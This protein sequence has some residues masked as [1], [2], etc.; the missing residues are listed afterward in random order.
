MHAAVGEQARERAVDDGRPDLRLD[1]VADDRQARLA[2]AVGP[3]ALLG[4]EHR[5]A[6]HEPA[7]GLEDL[8]DVPLGGL[9]G[10]DREVGDD[11]VGLGLLEDLD[12][13]IGLARRL[14][15][16]LLE[17]LAE[18]VVRHAAVHR[19]VEVGHVGEL[20]RVVLTRPDRLAEVLADLVGVDVERGR[21][22]DVAH[23]VAAEVDVHETGDRLVGIGVA[24]VL[25]ALHERARAVA[26]PHDGHAHLFGLVARRAVSSLSHKSS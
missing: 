14:G 25:H 20:D 26:D 2:E 1:V 4:D 9:L 23:V 6:V 24:V 21:E 22:L 3:V 10:A 15:D 12:D 5:D 8:L 13:V 19:D 11:H 16:L 17:V 7:A 18:A